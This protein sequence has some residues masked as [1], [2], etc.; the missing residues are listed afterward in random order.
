MNPTNVG[1]QGDT[2]QLGGDFIFGPGERLFFQLR[3]ALLNMR[4]LRQNEGNTCS[5]ASR[6]E[7]TADRKRK[8]GSTTFAASDC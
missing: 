8:L 5:F 1:K 6:M 4:L 3:R 7:H 2:A